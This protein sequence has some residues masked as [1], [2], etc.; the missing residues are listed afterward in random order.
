[1]VAKG[2]SQG[3]QIVFFGFINRNLLRSPVRNETSLIP[4]PQDAE[5][6]GV[7]V[8]HESRLDLLAVRAPSG[9]TARILTMALS[10]SS[11]WPAA[12]AG[13]RSAAHETRMRKK[14]AFFMTPVPFG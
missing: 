11:A 6:R 3:G 7:V 1:M 8:P 10:T 13:A 12:W 2:R 4:T 5:P 14:D 9:I